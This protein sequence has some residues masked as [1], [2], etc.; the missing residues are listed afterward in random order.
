MTAIAIQMR[1]SVD[2]LERWLANHLGVS[3]ARLR[4]STAGDKVRSA[5]DTFLASSS[6][7]CEAITKF[8]KRYT[9]DSAGRYVIYVDLEGDGPEFRTDCQYLDQIG[10]VHSN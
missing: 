5:F 4:D 10:V 1:L 8:V 9:Y 3:E 7:G 2:K 6:L